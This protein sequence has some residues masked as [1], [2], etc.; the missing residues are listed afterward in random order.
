MVDFI[1]V[2][3]GKAQLECFNFQT[4]LPH[5][6]ENHD[7][8][9]TKKCYTLIFESKENIYMLPLYIKFIQY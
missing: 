7:A 1:I 4:F 3:K 6:N 5:F 9:E 2:M 8:D